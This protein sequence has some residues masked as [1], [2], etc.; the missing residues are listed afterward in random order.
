MSAVDEVVMDIIGRNTANMQG[1]QVEDCQ[2]SFAPSSMAPPGDLVVYPHSS[3]V[4]A[5]L[6]TYEVSIQEGPSGLQQNLQQNSG[7]N[8]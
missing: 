8:L 4:Q 5:E 7:N 6:I 2:V 3:D 1:L